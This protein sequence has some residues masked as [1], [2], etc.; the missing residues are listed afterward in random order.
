MDG[1]FLILINYKWI[2]F[3]IAVLLILSIKGIS[4]SKVLKALQEKI[5]QNLRSHSSIESFRLF[6]VLEFR[7]KVFDNLKNLVEEDDQLKRKLIAQE[8]EKEISRCFLCGGTFEK[9]LI[10]LEIEDRKLSLPGERC[11]KCGY[12]AI[13]PEYLSNE[14]DSEIEMERDPR[15]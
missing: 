10:R 14:R 9:A 6:G 4:L 7:L 11:K 5:I 13:L 1:I 3:I 15:D 8:L 12:E 2:F